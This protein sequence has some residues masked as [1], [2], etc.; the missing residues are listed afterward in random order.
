MEASHRQELESEAG[1]LPG[2]ACRSSLVE[3]GHGV[4]Q[5][6]SDVRFGPLLQMLL[7]QVTGRHQECAQGELAQRPGFLHGG[8]YR[9]EIEIGEDRTRSVVA[10]EQLQLLAGVLESKEERFGGRSARLAERI[11]QRQRLQ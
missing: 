2:V 3:E 7:G 5:R 1:H 4:V 9:G 11:E 8:R 10:D 6:R